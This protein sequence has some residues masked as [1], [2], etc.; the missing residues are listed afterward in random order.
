MR[1][2]PDLT[3]KTRQHP[4]PGSKSLYEKLKAI[5]VLSSVLSGEYKTQEIII[6]ATK[7]IVELIKDI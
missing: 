6:P 2:I 3:D 4:K 5:E 1:M 7:K